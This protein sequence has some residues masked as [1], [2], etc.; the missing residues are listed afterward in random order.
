MKIPKFKR[1]GIGIIAEFHGIPSGFPNRDR[2][3]LGPAVP[4][5]RNGAS[6]LYLMSIYFSQERDSRGKL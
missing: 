4:A 3:F 2:T 6:L 1:S 5:P